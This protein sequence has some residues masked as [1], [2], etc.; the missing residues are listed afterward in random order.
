[1]F[2]ND[3]FDVNVEN[4]KKLIYA[5]FLS[6]SY[7]INK[8][9]NNFKNLNSTIIGFGSVSGLLGRNLNTN[10]AAAKRGLELF[11]ESLAFDENFK[12]TKIQFYTLGYLD[13]N[14]AF[15]KKI[16]LPK[17]SIKKLAQIVYENKNAS[18]KKFLSQI[19]SIIGFFLK[20]LPFNLVI[21]LY[22]VFN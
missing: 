20:I 14:L 22:K 16:N 21:K 8:L 4:S 12:N 10:Y 2:E 18:Y 13:T 5:N 6:I 3:K 7:I 1:M 19:L 11:F 9:S 15:G 17:G